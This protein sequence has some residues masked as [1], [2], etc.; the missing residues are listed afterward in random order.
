LKWDCGVIYK[1][2]VQPAEAVNVEFVEPVHPTKRKAFSS[3]Q[4]LAKPKTATNEEYTA[5]INEDYLYE[6]LYKVAPN[7]CLYTI[8]PEPV[9]QSDSMMPP[10]SIV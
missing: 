4:P 3:I 2:S 9:T 6:S 8:I 7:A 5:K 1:F 10:S